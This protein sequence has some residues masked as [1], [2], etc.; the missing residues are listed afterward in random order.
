LAGV[1]I[2]IN[3]ISAYKQPATM[4]DT[5]IRNI[6]VKPLP[7]TNE[8]DLLGRVAE[9]DE[10]AFGVIFHHYRPRIYSYA[11]HLSGSSGQADELVQEVFLKIWLNRDKIPHVLRFDNWL[12]TIARNQVFDMLKGMAK[13]ASARRQMAELQEPEG[14]SVEDSLLS[15]E[16]ELRLQQALERLSPRQKL[17]FTLSRHQGMKHEEIASRLHISRHTVKTHLVQALKTLRSVLHFHSEIVLPLCVGMIR[18][19]LCQ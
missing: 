11:F 12:F 10:K 16:N 9:G 14:G 2:E 4:F 18:Y 15:K 5:Q 8:N 17:I 1:E 6:A 7:L 3:L 13:E 19:L